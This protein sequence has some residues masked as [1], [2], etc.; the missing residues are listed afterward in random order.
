MKRRN[1]NCKVKKMTRWINFTYIRETT[2]G[3]R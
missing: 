1:E 3:D 2:I